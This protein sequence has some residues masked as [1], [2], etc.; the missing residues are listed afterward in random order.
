MGAAF[1]VS[2]PDLE[3]CL[4]HKPPILDFPRPLGVD[5]FNLGRV[6]PIIRNIYKFLQ[7]KRPV[8]YMKPLE[9]GWN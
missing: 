8:T 1:S 9:N 6:S 7:E 4:D 2:K 3:L 5:Q